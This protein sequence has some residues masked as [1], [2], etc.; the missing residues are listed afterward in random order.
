MDKLPIDIRTILLH[1]DAVCS[2][3]LVCPSVIVC[4]A[5]VPSYIIIL[6]G[7]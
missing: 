3:R 5:K 2:N 1:F 7:D 6:F 4:V